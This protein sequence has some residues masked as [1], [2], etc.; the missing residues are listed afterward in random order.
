L[1]KLPETQLGKLKERFP[2]TE[3]NRF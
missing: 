1:V 3:M 2:M